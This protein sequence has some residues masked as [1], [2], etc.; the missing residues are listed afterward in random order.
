M[1]VQ[2][3]VLVQT[4]VGKAAE[5]A[6]AIAAIKGV[7]LAEDVTG[8]YDVIV[9]AEGPS[10]STSSALSW[11]R[12]SRPSR[13]SPARSRVPSS[14]SDRRGPPPHPPP[15]RLRRHRRRRR[16]PHRRRAPR[17]T[18]RPSSPTSP[19][20]SPARTALDV[21]GRVAAAWGDPA[22]ILRCG[23]E[24][25]EAL[26]PSSR[27]FEVSDV[28]WLAETTADGYLFTTIGRAFHVSVEVPKTYDP[29]ADALADLAPTVKKH[30]PERGALRLASA[31]R[32]GGPAPA[33]AAGRRARRR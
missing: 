23:V 7:T 31:G 33:A 9:R 18:A 19:A 30:D 12:A 32:V 16:V 14:R 26:T 3:Y 13:A 24:K 17:S 15:H 8:P 10:A 25:P 4:E 20:A 2:A 22:I 6:K 27:C 11:S 1:V 28:G 21:P 29:A 5:V